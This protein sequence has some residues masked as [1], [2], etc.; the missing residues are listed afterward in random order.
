[1]VIDQGIQEGSPAGHWSDLWTSRGRSCLWQNRSMSLINIACTSLFHV[2]CCHFDLWIWQTT[3]S[4][5]MFF[6]PWTVNTSVCESWSALQNA[7]QGSSKL[8]DS[9]CCSHWPEHWTRS[10]SKIVHP[11]PLSAH[12]WISAPWGEALS[13]FGEAACETVCH[14]QS[15][16]G[17][18]CQKAIFFQLCFPPPVSVL[19]NDCRCQ[20][21]NCSIVRLH[22]HLF[23]SP[24]KPI[25]I[26]RQVESAHWFKTIHQLGHS[27]QI[28]FPAR[29][30]LELLEEAREDVSKSV[31][32]G[33]DTLAI[34]EGL[35][36]SCN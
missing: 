3:N 28:S 12:L 34:V 4:I 14:S 15:D 21:F 8:V 19:T 2:L 5:G 30:S 11:L 26:Q 20:C 32:W 10:L 1:M 9:D 23:A 6:S 24:V 31:C 29:N 22:S 33:F 25:V 18:S 13:L 35:T 16:I 36:G 7:K 17:L 27:S